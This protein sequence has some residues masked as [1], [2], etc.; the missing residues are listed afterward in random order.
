MADIQAFW[1]RAVGRHDDN[2]DLDDSAYVTGFAGGAV[3][4][5][6]EAEVRP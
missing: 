2:P 6:D 5:H 4:I 1:E 3:E